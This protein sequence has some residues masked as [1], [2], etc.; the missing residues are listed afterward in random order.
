MQKF[1][2]IVSDEKDFIDLP[3]VRRWLPES[4]VVFAD[5]AFS[6][7][8]VKGDVVGS[9]YNFLKSH[10]NV[11]CVKEVKHAGNGANS[12]GSGR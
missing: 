8:I 4:S 7:V 5:D 9:A 12:K 6:I 10:P 1:V 3:E 2:E 11:L